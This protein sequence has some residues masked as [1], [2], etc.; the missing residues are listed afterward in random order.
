MTDVPDCACAQAELAMFDRR[1]VVLPSAVFDTWDRSCGEPP[2]DMAN[3]S[4]RLARLA[5]PSAPAMTVHRS[6]Q[7]NR[8]H[9]GIRS[10]PRGTCTLANHTR[11]TTDLC[12]LPGCACHAADVSLQTRSSPPGRRPPGTCGLPRGQE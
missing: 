8:V 3:A 11:Q 12:E 6:G 1:F 4:A 10:R 2:R 5:M 9:V 7:R